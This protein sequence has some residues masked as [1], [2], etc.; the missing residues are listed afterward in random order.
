[1][2]IATI[3]DI[4]IYAFRRLLVF[5]ICMDCFVCLKLIPDVC[6]CVCCFFRRDAV[7]ACDFAVFVY[8]YHIAYFSCLSSFAF[9]SRC[10]YDEF[11]SFYERRTGECVSAFV[12]RYQTL[13]TVYVCVC[14]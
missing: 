7:P 14:V 6:V 1:M 9:I 8:K 4:I 11:S 3:S 5:F 12:R 2:V 10:C 13:E